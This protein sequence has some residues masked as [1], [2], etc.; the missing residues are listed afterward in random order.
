M[1]KFSAEP[2]RSMRAVMQAIDEVLA[3]QRIDRARI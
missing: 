2:T 3:T 1:P